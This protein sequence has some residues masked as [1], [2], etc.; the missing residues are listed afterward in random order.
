M[1]VCYDR[2]GPDRGLGVIAEYFYITTYYCTAGTTV[3]VVYCTFFSALLRRL[4][5]M[6]PLGRRNVMK[7]ICGYE[8]MCCRTVLVHYLLCGH[9]LGALWGIDTL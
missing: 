2:E 4:T 9:F 8:G 1:N 3:V 7:P 6:G 5:L